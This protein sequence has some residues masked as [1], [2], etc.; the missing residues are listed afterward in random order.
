MNMSSEHANESPSKDM[1][2][3]VYEPNEASH[4][5]DDSIMDLQFDDIDPLL[6]IESLENHSVTLEGDTTVKYS[7]EEQQQVDSI[8]AALQCEWWDDY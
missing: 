4:P 8:E 6:M 7:E 5:N 2:E 3:S 1:E